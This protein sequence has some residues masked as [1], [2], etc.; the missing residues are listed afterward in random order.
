ME[1][2]YAEFS[3]KR[4][5]P[6]YINALKVVLIVVL[7]ILLLI[8]MLSRNG[9]MI[10]LGVGAAA[11]LGW[12]WPRFNVTW[13]YVYCDGQIDFDAILGQDKRKSNLRID[14]DDADII[15]PEKSPALDGYRHLEVRDY[16]SR[17][18]DVIRYGIATKIEGKD[19]KILIYF[20][21]NEKMLTL[22][23]DKYPNKSK[24]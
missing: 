3:V 18:K 8:A 1:Q 13:E 19:A 12:Y 20:E 4:N 10:A 5:N 11:L 15:A 7:V 14:L 6:P 23:K 22:I 17:R 24:L 9:I 2:A 16:S 21:P